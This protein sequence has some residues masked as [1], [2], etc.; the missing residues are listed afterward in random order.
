MRYLAHAD[1]YES[2]E[3]MWWTLVLSE[4]LFSDITGSELGSISVYFLLTFLKPILL[5]YLDYFYYF[6]QSQNWE[7]S[8]R[9]PF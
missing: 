1:G 8:A 9:L 7:I 5:K 4:L 6:S 2:R 3:A